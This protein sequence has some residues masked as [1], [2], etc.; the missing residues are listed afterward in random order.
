MGR[1]RAAVLIA[2]NA[3]SLDEIWR[4]EAMPDSI[5][6]AGEDARA[7]LGAARYAGAIE[8]IWPGPE[9]M[10]MPEV[11]VGDKAQLLKLFLYK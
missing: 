1:D 6:E 4:S 8:L 10:V 11:A 9:S 5:R 7:A 3:A 2:G